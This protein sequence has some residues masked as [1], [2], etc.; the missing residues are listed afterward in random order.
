VLNTQSAEDLRAAIL[1]VRA[2]DDRD[3][4]KVMEDFNAPLASHQAGYDVARAG[5][6][7]ADPEA[8]A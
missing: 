5:Y 3:V 8:L 2:S 6:L 7:E 1:K 4:S